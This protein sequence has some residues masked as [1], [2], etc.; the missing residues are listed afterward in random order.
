MR[1][2]GALRRRGRCSREEG[3]AGRRGQRVRRRRRTSRKS[4]AEPAT[5]AA[6]ARGAATAAASGTAAVAVGAAVAAAA[7][8]RRGAATVAAAT[9]ELAQE[10][11]HRAT[12]LD[13]QPLLIRAHVLAA[14]RREERTLLCLR[15]LQP[16]HHV[17]EVDRLIKILARSAAAHEHFQL[18]DDGLLFGHYRGEPRARGRRTNAGGFSRRGELAEASLSQ[19]HAHLL[20]VVESRCALRP[21]RTPAEGEAATHAAGCVASPSGAAP[22]PSASS[23]AGNNPPRARVEREGGGRSASLVRSALALPTRPTPT[24]QAGSRLARSR[25]GRHGHSPLQYSSGLDRERIRMGAAGA[26]RKAR[27]LSRRTAGR[28]LSTPGRTLESAEQ[29]LR[30]IALMSL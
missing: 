24:Q 4:G 27:R 18:C 11:D 25:R 19:L 28:A 22:P 8:S 15:T 20:L 6:A 13:E 26:C 9:R 3:V 21:A 5:A 10:L 23:V 30:R 29:R 12:L 16:R 17:H 2:Q 1:L 14:L 7:A